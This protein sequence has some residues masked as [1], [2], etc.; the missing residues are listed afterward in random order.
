MRRR[1]CLG[2]HKVRGVLAAITANFE[3]EANGLTPVG[4]GTKIFPME[5][6]FK[7]YFYSTHTQFE[8]LTSD[9]KSEEEVRALWDEMRQ[10]GRYCHH[11]SPKSDS[12]YLED[13]YTGD[14]YRFSDHWGDVASC[15]WEN[16]KS[17]DR[18]EIAKSNLSNFHRIDTWVMTNEG[19]EEKYSLLTKVTLKHLDFLS[20]PNRQFFLNKFAKELLSETVSNLCGSMKDALRLNS[21]EIEELN[22]E[23]PNLDII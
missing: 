9:F 11:K 22:C 17:S 16:P 20:R 2:K 18:F 5:V 4:Y 7:D 21:D 10:S 6:S 3:R 23:F 15:I 12:E 19:V 1:K 13:V 8:C 14:I